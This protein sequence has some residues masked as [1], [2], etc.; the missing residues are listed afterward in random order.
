MSDE[1]TTVA[2]VSVR[3]IWEA[4]KA[5]LIEL[6]NLSFK[7]KKKGVSTLFV[8]GK[9]SVGEWKHKQEA[10]QPG[11]E[12]LDEGRD[13]IRRGVLVTGVGI[14]FGPV[15]GNLIGIDI[16]STDVATRDRISEAYRRICGHGPLTY[17]SG[18]GHYV[19]YR[20]DDATNVKHIAEV[21]NLGENEQGVDMHIEVRWTG[22]SVA[23]GSQHENGKIY[24]WDQYENAEVPDMPT[25]TAREHNDFVH[26]LSALGIDAKEIQTQSIAS[27]LP[28]SIEWE[29]GAKDVIDAY[30]AR[31]EIGDS[32]RQYGYKECGRDYW[33]HPNN[34]TNLNGSCHALNDKLCY[35]FGMNDPM[36]GNPTSHPFKLYVQYE[37]H[38]DYSAAVR[39]ISQEYGMDK[40]KDNDT[41]TPK[42]H[43]LLQK[44]VAHHLRMCLFLAV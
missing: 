12:L 25:I 34:D 18:K 36:G 29:H 31:H 32:L 30:N 21:A 39:A 11:D 41:I 37:H 7:W 10:I 17:R 9:K 16:D 26:Y 5:R 24:Q 8:D 28:K 2:E 42:D 23:P 13:L 38:G 3:E 33:M 14:I 43:A 19:L 1:N 15:S 44:Q 40:R 22:Y 6:G 4:R 35:H 27:S 20:V